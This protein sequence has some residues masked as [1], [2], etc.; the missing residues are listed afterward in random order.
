MTR[1]NQVVVNS[2]CMNALLWKDNIFSVRKIPG[3]F[4]ADVNKD[5]C[6]G[7]EF[8]YVNQQESYKHFTLAI[9]HTRD[10]ETNKFI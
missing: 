3:K 9:T 5:Q 8:D 10:I 7:K 4:L 2:A 1:S 6:R